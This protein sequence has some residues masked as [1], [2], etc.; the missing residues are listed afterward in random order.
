MMRSFEGQLM[1]QTRGYFSKNKDWYGDGKLDECPP[2]MLRI[3][4]LQKLVECFQIF[5]DLHRFL[6]MLL[7]ELV[8]QIIWDVEPSVTF[9]D[10]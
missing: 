9:Q 6:A 1:A 8:L 2:T 5:H 7:K 10:D 4:K 3:E